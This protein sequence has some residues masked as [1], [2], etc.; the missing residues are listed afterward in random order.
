M[1]YELTTP[2]LFA[3]ILRWMAPGIFRQ[4]EVLAGTVGTVSVPM[5]KTMDAAAVKVTS[6]NQKP[7]PFTLEGG[8]LRFF[9]GAPG[10]V[11]VTAGDREMVYSLTLPDVAEKPWAIPATAK[12]GIP[13]GFAGVPV[14][15][16]LWPWLAL[17]GGLGLFLDW[18][19]YGRWR[20]YKARTASATM[21]FPKTPWRKAS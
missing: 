8:S 20:A 13:R 2:I 3:N 11:R 6:E 14:G 16:E 19:L 18:M 7:L 9:S 21:R 5:D 12:R 4:F 15:R 1:K 17:A 10:L